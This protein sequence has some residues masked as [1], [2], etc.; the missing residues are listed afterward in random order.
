MVGKL[1][2]RS[3]KKRTGKTSLVGNENLF[4]RNA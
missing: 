1:G 2:G 3:R 4:F